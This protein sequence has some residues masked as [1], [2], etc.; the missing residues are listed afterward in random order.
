[1]K[2]NRFDLYHIQS[3][4]KD[5]L[6][7]AVPPVVKSVGDV[8]VLGDSLVAGSALELG[9]ALQGGLLQAESQWAFG[10]FQLSKA[11]GLS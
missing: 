3:S 6:F 4:K 9:D 10:S 8:L 5:D 11:L 7:G 1:M 2:K